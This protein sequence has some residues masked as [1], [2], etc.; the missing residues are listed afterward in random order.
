MVIYS[1]FS[2]WK[3]GDFSIV[4]LDYQRVTIMFSTTATAENSGAWCKVSHLNVPPK[5]TQWGW[6]WQWREVAMGRK[7]HLENDGKM[8]LNEILWYFNG[9]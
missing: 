2:H 9:I 4:M 5:L 8:G 1:G 3:N 7:T 6:P